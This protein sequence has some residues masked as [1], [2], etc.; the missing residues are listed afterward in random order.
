MENVDM[1]EEIEWAKH[2]SNQRSVVLRDLVEA[3][4]LE[5]RAK[6]KLPPHDPSQFFVNGIRQLQNHHVASRTHSNGL[7]RRQANY[8]NFQAGQGLGVDGL[9]YPLE[10]LGEPLRL[11]AGVARNADHSPQPLFSS[12]N[13]RTHND[14]LPVPYP[15]ALV[16]PDLSACKRLGSRAFLPYEVISLIETMFTSKGEMKMIRDLCGD[17]AQTFIDVI[18]EV[19]S[20]HFLFRGTV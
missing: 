14:D 15:S 9:N 19:P 2:K 18:Y 10:H 20:T 3:E 7:T 5:K 11:G 12:G 4:E 1:P 17:E 8:S 6:G 16:D 13:T